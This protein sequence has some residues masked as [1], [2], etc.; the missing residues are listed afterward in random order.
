MRVIATSAAGVVAGGDGVEFAGANGGTAF[1]VAVV[2]VGHTGS[3]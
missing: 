1:M 3:G 2:V